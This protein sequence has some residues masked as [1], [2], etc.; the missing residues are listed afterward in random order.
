MRRVLS[1]WGES[2]DAAP[3]ILGKWQLNA[4]DWFPRATKTI[5]YGWTGPSFEAVPWDSGPAWDSSSSL[6][7]IELKPT[8]TLA[9]SSGLG[10]AGGLGSKGPSG[11]SLEPPLVVLFPF[12]R[13]I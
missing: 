13:L 9:Q 6:L 5:E 7:V 11:P 2:L 1:A 3:I 12:E 4:D 8:S 10:G